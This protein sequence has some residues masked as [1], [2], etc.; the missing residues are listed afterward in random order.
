MG[1]V[2]GVRM[3]AFRFDDCGALAIV[4]WCEV[5]RS[6]ARAL[7]SVIQGVTVAHVDVSLIGFEGLF[8]YEMTIEHHW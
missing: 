2:N 6:Q 5:R 7:C 8:Y 3:D 4:G 1:E